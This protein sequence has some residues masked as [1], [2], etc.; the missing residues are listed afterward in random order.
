MLVPE[1]G[2]SL[3]AAPLEV[4]DDTPVR[5]LR[6]DD[7]VVGDSVFERVRFSKEMLADFAQVAKDRAPVHDDPRFARAAGFAGPIVQGLALSTRFSRLI[8]MYLPGGHAILESVEL[9]FRRP[10]YA[11]QD[12]IFRA[13]VDRVFRP[14]RVVTLA[15]TISRQDTHHVTGSAR[16]LV[17]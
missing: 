16:C 12:V 15:L 7:L 14:L 13:V 6:V 3:A 1:R 8:G 11:D 4:F 5:H 2:A 17:R 9:K 10:V